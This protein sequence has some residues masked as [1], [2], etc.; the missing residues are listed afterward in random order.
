[1]VRAEVAASS[2]ECA[3]AAMRMYERSI[4]S[5]SAVA[6]P[7]FSTGGY[8]EH[9]VFGKRERLPGSWADH[10]LCIPCA[11]VEHGATDGK[12]RWHRYSAAAEQGMGSRRVQFPGYIGRTG[13]LPVGG[14][15][16]CTRDAKIVLKLGWRLFWLIPK[17]GH[18]IQNAQRQIVTYRH[19]HKQVP[20]WI[21]LWY[22]TMLRTAFHAWARQPTTEYDAEFQN[23]LVWEPQEGWR[24]YEHWQ[25]QHRNLR[26]RVKA[27]RHLAKT[28][29]DKKRLNAQCR[30]A[31]GFGQEQ[32]PIASKVAWV[33]ANS[34]EMVQTQYKVYEQHCGGS[35][36]APEF[37]SPKLWQVFAMLFMWYIVCNYELETLQ[38][39]MQQYNEPT[40]KCVQV[41]QMQMLVI[42]L[43]CKNFEPQKYFGPM[44]IVKLVH[45]ERDDG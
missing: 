3:R 14:C 29:R 45:G 22:S 38:A 30:A 21:R 2:E 10:A 34:K 27:H 39:E 19:M 11:R 31:Q 24:G 18:M 37:T 6:F 26:S 1:M 16:E 33:K 7:G 43:L 20:M 5:G 40:L 23:S 17:A 8:A 28:R 41:K 42:I 32:G 4:T 15:L 35:R 25:E 12:C 9:Q 13:W 44:D 36:A